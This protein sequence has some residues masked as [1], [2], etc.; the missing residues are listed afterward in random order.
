MFDYIDFVFSPGD[1]FKQLHGTHVLGEAYTNACSG[2]MLIAW[3][4]N[5]GLL[6]KISNEEFKYF[7]IKWSF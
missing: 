2:E 4:I 5:T 1:R 7:G 6:E 3:E